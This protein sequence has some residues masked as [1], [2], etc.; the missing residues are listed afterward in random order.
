METPPPPAHN[1]LLVVSSLPKLWCYDLCCQHTTVSA[2]QAHTHKKETGR[3]PFY[4]LFPYTFSLLLCLSLSVS[5]PRAPLG[6]E[7]TWKSWKVLSL[8]AKIMKALEGHESCVG[9]LKVLVFFFCIPQLT[10]PVSQ[11]QACCSWAISK[12]RATW[13]LFRNSSV[14]H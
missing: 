8:Q 3:C 9:T 13:I 11:G 5:F 10:L 7:S 2:E 12:T 6:S 4:P 14:F 1:P